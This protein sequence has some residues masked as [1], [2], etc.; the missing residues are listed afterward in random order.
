MGPRAASNPGSRREPEAA[1]RPPPKF[2]E[3]GGVGLGLRWGFLDELLDRLEPDSD[4]EPLPHIPFFEIS[5]ENYMRRGGFIP[6]AIER[7]AD[8][9]PVLTHGLT[10][11]VGG[12][13]PFEPAYMAELARFCAHMRVPFHSD[14]LCFGGF[15]G[16]VLHDLLPLPLTREAAA[17]VARRAAEAQERLG[18]P[19]VLE[20]VT[21][22]FVPGEP[23]VG[24]ADF[25]TEV[26]EAS[27]TR[28]L[29]DVN[30]VVV[31]AKNYGFDPLGFVDALPLD[32]VV[33]VHVAGHERSDEDAL[34]IDTHGA[35]VESPVLELLRHVVSRT[36]PVPVVLERDHHIP[37]L[38]ELLLELERVRASYERGIAA[39]SARS[40]AKGDPS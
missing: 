19:F 2:P 38:D 27:D 37:P 40:A 5:P 16:S 32:R 24:E 13:D 12:L 3:R 14:H 18:V 9:Y 8:R 22:Y 21:H 39:F 1:E 34:W 6:S 4:Q 31:N 11:G 15:G 30:N 33:Q 35:S 36:G 29:L 26:L 17:H 23:N 7:I 25:I 20:N 10:L 28:L